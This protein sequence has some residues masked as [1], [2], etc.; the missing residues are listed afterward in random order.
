MPR[1]D[2]NITGQPPETPRHTPDLTLSARDIHIEE[3][4]PTDDADAD[5]EEQP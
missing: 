2:L 4:P 3:E 5:G 1:I